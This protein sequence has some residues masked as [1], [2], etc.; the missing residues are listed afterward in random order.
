MFLRDPKIL[1]LE[2]IAS[3]LDEQGRAAVEKAIDTAMQGRTVLVMSNQESLLEKCDSMFVIGDSGTVVEQGLFSNLSA[4]PD[5]CYSK[6][7]RGH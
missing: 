1:I 2:D 5:S 6:F 3:K 4:N 7:R